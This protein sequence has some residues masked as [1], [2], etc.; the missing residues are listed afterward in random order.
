MGKRLFVGNISYN[1][2]EDTLREAF[3][4]DGRTVTDVHIVMDRESGRPR[5][6]AFVELATEADAQA[7][8][9]ALDGSTL[10][11]RPIKVNVA[12]ARR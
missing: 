5:G 2:S 4:A 3:S 8:I 12:Q 6:F 9:E 10:D 11:G 7:A 1:A